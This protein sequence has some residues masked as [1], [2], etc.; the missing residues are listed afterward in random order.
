MNIY[1]TNCKGERRKV[2]EL[3]YKQRVEEMLL[4]RKEDQYGHNIDIYEEIEQIYANK[5][6]AANVSFVI[7]LRLWKVDVDKVYMGTIM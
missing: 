4:F 1:S 5:K 6:D 2:K 7:M 3:S